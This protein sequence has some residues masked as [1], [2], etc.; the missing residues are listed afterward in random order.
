MATITKKTVKAAPPAE[1][2]RYLFTV[3]QFERMGK[4]GILDEDDRVELIEGELI[5]MAAI[6]NRHVAY[7]NRLTAVL[8][9]RAHTV[10]TVSVQN[11]ARLYPMSEPQ[12]DLVLSRLDA[13]GVPGGIPSVA[14]ILLVI[15]VADSSLRYDLTRKAALYAEK[16]VPE[17]WVWNAVRGQVHVFRTPENGSYKEQ[18]IA[19]RGDTLEVVALPGVRVTV[20][21]I[22]EPEVK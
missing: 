3:E 14:E 7:V 19:R 9:L 2:V 12:P 20:R 16:G 8:V 10:A 17:L 21:E 1:P 4:V 5:Q 15:E 13:S 6:G 22:V 18:F 11:P